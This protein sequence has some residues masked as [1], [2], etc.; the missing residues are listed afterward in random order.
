MAFARPTFPIIFLV[1]N[2][3]ITSVF[4]VLDLDE[5]L[6]LT[7]HWEFRAE[8]DSSPDLDMMEAQRAGNALIRKIISLHYSPEKLSLKNLYFILN[9]FDTNSLISHLLCSN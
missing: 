6:N 9:K 2:P 4:S 1:P 3:G 5:V 7:G 8:K